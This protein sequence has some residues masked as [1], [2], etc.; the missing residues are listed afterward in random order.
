MIRS[1]AADP[2]APQV[3]YDSR[4][5]AP[6]CLQALAGGVHPVGSSRVWLSQDISH[7]FAALISLRP[8]LS[9]PPLVSDPALA[10]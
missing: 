1:V 7:H 10:F 8:V 5:R 2:A 4:R 6:F 9:R 3:A